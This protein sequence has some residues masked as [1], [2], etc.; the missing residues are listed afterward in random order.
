MPAYLYSE[1]QRGTETHFRRVTKVALAGDNI[2]QSV[3][4]QLGKPFNGWHV[5]QEQLLQSAVNW[6]GRPPDGYHIIIDSAPSLKDRVDLVSLS[7]VYAYTYPDQNESGDA[8]WSVLM[9]KCRSVFFRDKLSPA[10]KDQL[11][12]EF[13]PRADGDEYVT[14]LYLRDQWLF[15]RLGGMNGAWLDW[16]AR[17][18]FSRFWLVEPH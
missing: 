1:I 7:D 9:L 8:L 6:A 11:S 16:E 3:W 15:G 17:A 18:Y 2:I 12:N 13:P 14:F 5:N 10:E 4:R